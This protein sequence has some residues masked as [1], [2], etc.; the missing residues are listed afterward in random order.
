MKNE[1]QAGASKDNEDEEE[2]YSPIHH[3]QPTN[4]YQ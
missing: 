2:Q 1:R 4:Y 3:Q